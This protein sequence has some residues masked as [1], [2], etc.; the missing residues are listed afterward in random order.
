MNGL[1]PLRKL[2]SVRGHH[3]LAA[4]LD[5]SSVVVDLGAHQGDFSAE[6][7]ARF[8]CR[9]YAVEANPALCARMKRLP[10]VKVF[11][12]AAA[13][14]DG[15][16]SLRI[17]ANLEASNLAR[18][19]EPG[20]GSLVTVPGTTL[21]TFLRSRGIDRVDL[22]KVDIEG[23]EVEVFASLS[24][25]WLRH[26]GQITIEFHDFIERLHIDNEVGRIK[27]RLTSLGFACIV[28]SRTNNGD[29]LFVNRQHYEGSPVAWLYLERVSRY[30]RGVRRV[31]RRTIL[32]RLTAAR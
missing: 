20:S 12:Y 10:G 27:R 13:A 31:L 23:A 17:D 2:T 3:F 9:C 15:P 11:N 28:F 1:R 24:D 18:N 26:M 7:A 25:E 16:V 4:G 32:G 22:L 5:G 14:D 8:R 21:E 19:A 6:I 29:V 30:T